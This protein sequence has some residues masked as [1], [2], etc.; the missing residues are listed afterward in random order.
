MVI[1]K[2]S[3]KYIDDVARIEQVC[4]SAPWSR[5]SL[6][7]ELDNPSAQFLV[8][9]ENAKAIGYVGIHISLGEGDI[10]RVAV[11]PQFRRTG[12]GRA[13]LKECLASDKLDRVF[14]D[15]R[16]NNIPALRLYESFGFRRIGIRKNYYSN[17]TENAL[18][19]MWKK[20]ENEELL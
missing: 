17:P 14:L 16:E 7:G 2:F 19:M 8:A 12:T 18:M 15:V 6:A 10:M 13:L 5:E 11:L 20:T 3:R 1:K 9:V 4:F